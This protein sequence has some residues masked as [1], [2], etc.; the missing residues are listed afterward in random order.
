[1]SIDESDNFINHIIADTI[2]DLSDNTRERIMNMF[3]GLMNSNMTMLP[4]SSLNRVLTQ[5]LM[6][7]PPY[8]KILSKKGNEQLK[9]VKYSK[10]IFDQHSC[11]IVFEDFKE[12]QDVTQLPC[13][14]IFDCEGI[15]TWLKEESSKCPVCRFELD[16]KEVKE[17]QED[18]SNNYNTYDALF[19]NPMENLYPNQESF[20]NRIF[21]IE[22]EYL[23]NRNLQNAI[24]ASIYEQN[25]FTTDSDDELDED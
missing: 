5:S 9:I 12:G 20:I 8:K 19:N 2:H 18:I 3:T 17:I 23:E 16:F 24:I 6:E 25:D 10:D 13:N 22:T 21:N 15:K 11:C 4:N 14:H 7:N 1:M